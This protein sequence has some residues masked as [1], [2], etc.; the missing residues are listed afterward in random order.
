[1]QT[2]ITPE[3]TRARAVGSYDRIFYSGMAIAMAATVFAGFAP[4]YYLRG[5]TGSATFSG[6]TSIPPL[7]HLHGVLF[8]AWVLLFIV[9]TTLIARRQVA[10][11]RALGV[12]GVALAIA[13]VAVGWTTAVSAAARGSAPPGIEP[14][15][16]LVIPIFDM[17]LFAGFVSAA[18]AQRRNK[19]AHKRLM[20][21]AYASIV[22][23]AV[24]RL[25]GVMPLGPFGFFGLSFLFVVAGIVYDFVSRGR[26]H[27]VYVWGGLLLALSVPGRLMLS[28]TA[29]WRNVAQALVG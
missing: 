2:V 5:Y 18:I 25:P 15:V 12:A 11:H 10:T 27:P 19:E 3:R 14:L 4:T 6:L 28:G 23:A 1:M 8:T 9:Q 13:M 24:A 21:L 7:L 29:L 17:L 20:I 26:V 16:F 22:T